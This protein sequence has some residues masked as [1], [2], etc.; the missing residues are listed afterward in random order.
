MNDSRYKNNNPCGGRR[1]RDWHGGRESYK[2]S[3]FES[4]MPFEKKFKEENTK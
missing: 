2:Q 4:M 1:G 3:N